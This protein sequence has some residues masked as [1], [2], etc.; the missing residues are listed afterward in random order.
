MN[1]E[2]SRKCIIWFVVGVVV[3][4]IIRLVLGF[5]FIYSSLLFATN[6][7]KSANLSLMFLDLLSI[8]SISGIGFVL[9]FMAGNLIKVKH[10][11][12]NL[13]L[14]SAFIFLAITVGEVMFSWMVLL[15]TFKNDSYLLKIPWIVISLFSGVFLGK[16]FMERE[17]KN[18][19]IVNYIMLVVVFL[20][21]EI[22][23]MVIRPTFLIMPGTS[24]G[25]MPIQFITAFITGALIYLIGCTKMPKPEFSRF[26]LIMLLI[27]VSLFGLSLLLQ[28]TIDYSSGAI[29]TEYLL[30]VHTSEG[31]L[32]ILP[33][34]AG[35]FF[36]KMWLNG[37]KSDQIK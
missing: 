26:A 7:A 14:V 8:L 29:T 33:Y 30:K 3:F 16:F 19:I 9:V 18:K 10:G 35:F 21:F 1:R 6:T 34:F 31:M 25:S 12:N 32:A 24:L 37:H 2:S 5:G 28:Q 4:I 13:Y 36:L 17:S 23:A 22:S 15:G 20:I 11:K 27:C